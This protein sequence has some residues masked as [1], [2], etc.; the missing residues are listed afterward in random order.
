MHPGRDAR[1]LLVRKHEPQLS[2]AQFSGIGKEMK[3]Q[4]VGFRTSRIENAETRD[5]QH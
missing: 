1:I 3:R 4:E 2:L 5:K